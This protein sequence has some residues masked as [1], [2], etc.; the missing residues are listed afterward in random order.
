M[1]HP[2]EA[3]KGPRAPTRL[4][5]HEHVRGS[6]GASRDLHRMEWVIHVDIRMDDD[7][8]DTY[9]NM[10]DAFERAASIFRGGGPLGERLAALTAFVAMMEDGARQSLPGDK[11]V[12]VPGR[13]AINL[14]D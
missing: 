5:P 11:D 13:R 14:E 2:R 4:A 10:V 6:I 9:P 8:G 7:L 1:Q 12:P 3:R